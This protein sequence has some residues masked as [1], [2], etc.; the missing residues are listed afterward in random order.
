MSCDLM[1]IFDLY[2]DLSEIKFC[3][4][5]LSKVKERHRINKQNTNKHVHGEYW[6]VYAAQID[7]MVRSDYYIWRISDGST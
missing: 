4:S 5:R 7:L 1:R 3:A 6:K 2:S